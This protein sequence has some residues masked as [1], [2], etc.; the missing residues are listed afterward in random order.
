M[1]YLVFTEYDS[2]EI[3]IL[4]KKA[5]AIWAERE[6]APDKYPKQIFPDHYVLGDLPKFK[7]AIRGV[8]IYET[9][10][11][12]QIA[13]VVAYWEAQKPELKTIKRWFIPLTGA[14]KQMELIEK[15]KK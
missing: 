13:N 9:D 4:T 15:M 10:D 3:D 2:E 11:P 7:E 6:K 1:K 8:T 5:K 14:S 12:E